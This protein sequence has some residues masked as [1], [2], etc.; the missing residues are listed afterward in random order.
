MALYLGYTS[1]CDC[2]C[3]CVCVGAGG[4]IEDRIPLPTN[5]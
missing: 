1:V 4:D 2:V 5:Y 3:V